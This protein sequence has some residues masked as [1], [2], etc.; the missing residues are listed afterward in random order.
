MER[1]SD[2]KE[3]TV[4]SSLKLVLR[5]MIIIMMCGYFEMYAMSFDLFGRR[6]VL[7]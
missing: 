5:D 7:L 4:D 2:P 6:G 3:S 1:S